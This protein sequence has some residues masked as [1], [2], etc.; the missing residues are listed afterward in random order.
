M[1]PKLDEKKKKLQW[2]AINGTKLKEW[3]I[4]YLK[5]EKIERSMFFL[6]HFFLKILSTIDLLSANTTTQRSQSDAL[7]LFGN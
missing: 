5:A 4:V 1:H 7:W 3:D 2:L 6:L